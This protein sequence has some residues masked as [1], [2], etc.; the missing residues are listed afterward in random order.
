VSRRGIEIAGTAKCAIAVLD[1][2]AF[3][4]PVRCSHGTPPIAL[5][6]WTMQPL[7]YPLQRQKVR[8][9]ASRICMA[10]RSLETVSGLR[11]KH[12]SQRPQRTGGLWMVTGY[13]SLPHPGRRF[14]AHRMKRL[15]RSTLVRNPIVAVFEFDRQRRMSASP[16]QQSRSQHRTGQRTRQDRSAVPDRNKRQ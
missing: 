12:I 2:F 14:D 5:S 7:D 4:T 15:R 1:P 3:E 10:P 13:P 16:S 6:G 9:N 8:V 11:W